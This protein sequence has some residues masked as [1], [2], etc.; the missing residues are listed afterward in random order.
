MAL[1]L[2]GRVPR[3]TYQWDSDIILT[4]DHHESPLINY[5]KMEKEKP[6]N[7]RKQS[8]ITEIKKKKT[9]RS[10]KFCLG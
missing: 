3:Q 6:Q 1:R 2:L 5:T 8:D 7:C 9:S 4:S 10:E